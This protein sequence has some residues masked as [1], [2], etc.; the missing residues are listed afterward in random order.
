MMVHPSP[1]IRDHATYGRMIAARID[2]W[3]S[4][5]ETDDA[6]RAALA[7]EVEAARADLGRTCP[8]ILGTVDPEEVATHFRSLAAQVLVRT[9][10]SAG[11][12]ASV[13]WSEARGWIIVGGANLDRGF[14]IEGLTVTYMPRG[15]GQAGRRALIEDGRGLPQDS[16]FISESHITSCCEGWDPDPSRLFSFFNAGWV[17]E[18]ISLHATSSDLFRKVTLQKNPAVAPIER[19]QLCPREAEPW[20]FPSELSAINRRILP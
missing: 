4:L 17:P 10:N 14:T 1:L 9:V 15:M 7:A 16:K 5:S 19:S 20:R 12:P 6:C 2:H 8:E 11:G 18:I 13:E 3:R